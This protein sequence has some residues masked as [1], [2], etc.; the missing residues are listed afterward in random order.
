MAICL[1]RA[2]LLAFRLC[3]FTLCRLNY[4]C[5][6]TVWCLGKDVDFDIEHSMTTYTEFVCLI[7]EKWRPREI[8]GSDLV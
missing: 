2:V 4:L 8:H 7:S 3:Y 6:F 1:E 5:S